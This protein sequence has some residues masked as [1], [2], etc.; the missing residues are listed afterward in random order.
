MSLATS[1]PTSGALGSFCS[2]LLAQLFLSPAIVVSKLPK[3]SCPINFPSTIRRSGKVSAI[4]AKIC[5]QKCLSKISLN[6]FQSPKCSNIPGSLARQQRL[7]SNEKKSRKS[8][9]HPNLLKNSNIWYFIDLNIKLVLKVYWR[10]V[11]LI[12]K[13]YS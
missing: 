13:Y 7:N 10:Y 2:H 4:N 9:R 8:A 1:R 6:E 3:K 5:S 11:L 12:I